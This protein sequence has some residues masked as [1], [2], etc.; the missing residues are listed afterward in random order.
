MEK[1][2]Y[3]I[4]FLLEKSKDENLTHIEI[5]ELS[6]LIPLIRQNS[7]FVPLTHKKYLMSIMRERITSN[8]K[9]L[10]EISEQI[11]EIYSYVIGG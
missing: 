9:P 5:N 6:L 4:I 2:A 8:F 7:K 1:E 3:R 11:N 10:N